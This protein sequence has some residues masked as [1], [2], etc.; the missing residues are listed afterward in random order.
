MNKIVWLWHEHSNMMALAD[1]NNGG[2]PL[3][4]ICDNEFKGINPFYSYPLSFLKH[5]GWVEIGE[6][7]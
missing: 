1:L 7:T 5:Y 6:W 2:L 3:L 4:S